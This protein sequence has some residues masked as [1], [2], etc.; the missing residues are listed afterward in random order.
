MRAMGSGLPSARVSVA[1]P[2]LEEI[3]RRIRYRLLPLLIFLT[4]MLA[5]AVTAAISLLV[6]RRTVTGVPRDIEAEAA[7]DLMQREPP[8]PTGALRFRAELFGASGS[9]GAQQPAV[10]AAATALLARAETRRPLDARLPAALAHLDLARRRFDHAERGYRR[11]LL[12]A[13]G[14]GEARLGLG[15]A[16]ALHAERE[17]DPL[18]QRSLRLQAIAQFA[19][20]AASDPVREHA[21]YDRVVLLADVGRRAEAQ[22]RAADYLG[23]YRGSAWAESLT[24]RVPADR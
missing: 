17:A 19:A 18:E 8:P 10:V 24:A 14:Y 2:A 21:L 20:V 22:R 5:L 3:E 23:R 15:V 4:M 13:P 11:A 1:P 7:F 12:L 16:L 6:P 9:G